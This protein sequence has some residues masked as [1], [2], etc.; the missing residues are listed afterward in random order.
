MTSKFCRFISSS[1]VTI[2]SSRRLLAYSTD[3]SR[4]GLTRSCWDS[5][6][7]TYSCKRSTS[8]KSHTRTVSQRVGCDQRERECLSQHAER[9]SQNKQE[10]GPR[11]SWLLVEMPVR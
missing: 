2:K 1:R 6:T 3:V 4:L 7:S 8:T 11:L 5:S 9:S 10:A